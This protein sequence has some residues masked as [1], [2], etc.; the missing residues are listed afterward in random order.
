MPMIRNSLSPYYNTDILR[1]VINTPVTAQRGYVTRATASRL[2]DPEVS[3]Q[4]DK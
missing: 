3:W 4:M 1:Y 2:V